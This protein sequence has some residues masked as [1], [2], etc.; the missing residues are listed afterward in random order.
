MRRCSFE[1]LAI[2]T[3]SMS[4]A[5]L[6]SERSRR[7]MKCSQVIGMVRLAVKA[8]ATPLPFPDLILELIGLYFRGA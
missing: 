2:E 6:M 1:L 3:G 7:E 4:V 8:V 5:T